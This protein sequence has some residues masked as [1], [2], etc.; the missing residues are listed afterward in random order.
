MPVGR[1]AS[2]SV[3]PLGGAPT[4]EVLAAP[5]VG[6]PCAGP[7]SCSVLDTLVPVTVEYTTHTVSATSA[8]S[9]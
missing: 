4:I 8:G 6:G 3:S 5:M 9:A 7:E 2:N 1:L